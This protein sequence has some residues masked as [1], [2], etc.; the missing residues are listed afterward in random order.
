MLIV[1][2]YLI[3]SGRSVAGQ[4]LIAKARPDQQVFRG[5]RFDPV[6]R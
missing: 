3:A 6:A 5:G 2:M 1:L 4:S